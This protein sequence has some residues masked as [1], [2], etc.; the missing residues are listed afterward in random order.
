M[1]RHVRAGRVSA[2]GRFISATI[3]IPGSRLVASGLARNGSVSGTPVPRPSKR[4]E[5]PNSG[6]IFCGRRGLHGATEYGM[7]GG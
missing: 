1:L 5:V 6:I 3:S 4:R 7:D 2:H